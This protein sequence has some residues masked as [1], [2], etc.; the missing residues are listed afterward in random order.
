MT[1]KSQPIGL[2]V[3]TVRCDSPPPMFIEL[4]HPPIRPAAFELQLDAGFD[5]PQTITAAGAPRVKG[6]PVASRIRLN[7]ARDAR[8]WPMHAGVD[9]AHS[10]ELTLT[11]A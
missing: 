5:A 1:D 9:G 6:A 4:P 7:P 3:V 8:G 11:Q 10:V 2:T